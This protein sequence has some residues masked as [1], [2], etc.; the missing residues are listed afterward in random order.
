MYVIIEYCTELYAA[1]YI[2]I[3]QYC[4]VFVKNCTI[5]INYVQYAKYF[6]NTVQYQKIL[7]NYL[8]NFAHLAR[9]AARA[10]GPAITAAAA[11]RAAAEGPVPRA[12]CSG[13][14][15]CVQVSLPGGVVECTYSTLY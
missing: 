4:T 10:P 5:H 14:Y 3:V 15:S 11:P 6:T 13:H 12:Q 8:L 1:I 7:C 2:N 9:A